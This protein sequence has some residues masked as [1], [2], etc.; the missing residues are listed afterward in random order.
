MAGISRTWSPGGTPNCTTL[1][2][3]GVANCGQGVYYAEG[4][5]VDISG[6]L[7]RASGTL[8]SPYAMTLLVDGSVSISGS[9]K[10]IPA[11]A[12]PNILIVTNGDLDMT[13]TAN[14]DLAGQARVREQLNLAG[15]MLLTGQIIIENRW[16]HSD[17]V[18]G[19]S[20]VAGNA[21]V[22]NDPAGGVRLHGSR[23]ARVPTITP[24]LTC[25]ECVRSGHAGWGSRASFPAG[26]QLN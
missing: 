23:L 10:I 5:D 18:T 20:K 15:N 12:R 22:T 7:G 16:D 8:P 25:N 13:G 1:Q 9:P 24:D 2:A 14:C 4:S 17:T 11:I 19:D 26:P 21:T 6:N 3:H